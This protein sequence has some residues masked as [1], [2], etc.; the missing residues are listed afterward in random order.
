[1]PAK[2]EFDWM[3][4]EEAVLVSRQDHAHERA[5]RPCWK[6]H[7]SKNKSLFSADA[8]RLG[9]MDLGQALSHVLTCLGHP[10]PVYSCG[11]IGPG[12]MR[13]KKIGLG[14]GSGI[15]GMKG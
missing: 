2:F 9:R 12:T 4:V 8:E 6:H 7:N 1:V 13:V 10:V 3:I 11:K 15:G 5:M 14:G